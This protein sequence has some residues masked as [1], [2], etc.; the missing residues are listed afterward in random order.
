M[1]LDLL[2]W[3]RNRLQ[4][5]SVQR[6]TGDDTASGSGPE[7][8]GFEVGYAALA[9]L[10]LFWPGYQA[11]LNVRRGIS[12]R[13]FRTAEEWV[14]TVHRRFGGAEEGAVLLSNWEHLTPLWVHTYTQGG[15][16]HERDVRLVYVSTANPWVASVWA[17]IE[18]GPIYLP[19][20]RPAVRNEGFRLVPEGS[21]YRVVAPPVTDVAPEH[22]LDVWAEGRV[23]IL[24][25]DLATTIVHAGEP[26]VLTLYQS[27]SEPMEDIW[28]PYA[29]LGPLEARWT[30][31]SRVL[32]SQWLPGEVIVERYELPVPFGLAPGEYP[33]RLGYAD[34]SKGRAELD[35]LTGRGSADEHGVSPVA[36]ETITVLPSP[37]GRGSQRASAGAPMDV[38]ERSLANLDNQVALM[39][40]RARAGGQVRRAPWEAP[41]M[42][43]AGQPLHLTLNWRALASPRDSYTVFIHLIDGAGRYVTGHDYTPLGGACPTY[44]WFPKWLP[45]QVFMDPYRLVL[46]A[47]LPPGDYW[48]EAGMYGM[49]SLR[50][51][52]VV[53]LNGNLAGDRVILGSVRVE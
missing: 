17:H 40:A 20:Y 49:T 42:V 12:L 5:L 3:A 52:P 2:A 6:S 19:D 34:L 11:T 43:R 53:D 31:D 28:M 32:T 50:R 4:S 47:D 48:L 26:L 22:P 10:L 24:G 41:L 30:T 33:L 36:L 1:F 18:E 37:G 23:H 16:L 46:P 21:L 8:G 51:L 15:A 44:L 13:D 27:V 29:Y 14:A 9:V 35:L 25:Y 7:A 45:G 38:L 39:G